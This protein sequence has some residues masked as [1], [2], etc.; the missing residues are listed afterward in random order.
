MKKFIFPIFII[1]GLVFG[2][3]IKNVTATGIGAS[4]DG[5]VKNA[6][7]NAL[8][9]VVGAFI[10][11][12]TEIK[13]FQTVKD[14]ILSRT[15]GFIKSYD[16][17]SESEKEGQ[18][19][20]KITA[21][22]AE[23]KLEIELEELNVI[24]NKIGNPSILVFYLYGED[25]KEKY[26]NTFIEQSIRKVNNFLQDRKFRT[27]NFDHLNKVLKK[28]MSSSISS[29]ANM[30]N[31]K[32][33]ADKEKAD[34]FITIELQLPKKAKTFQTKVIAHLFNTSTGEE[35]GSEDGKS[36]KVFY[37]GNRIKQNDISDREINQSVKRLMPNVIRR[38][39]G[40]WKEMAKD[41]K[42]YKYFFH[43]V[44]KG[45]RSKR[46]LNKVV[47]K[48]AEKINKLS[49]TEFEI[50]YTGT[51]DEFQD[52]ILDDLIDNVYKGKEIDYKIE[53]DITHVH[54]LN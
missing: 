19:S 22:V 12:E 6:Q 8:E 11:S 9:K 33:V 39:K 15:Q 28:D 48:Y 47:K 46:N 27:Y 20:V 49:G 13:D 52:I 21:K 37:D 14:D 25:Q 30:E 4:L 1:I 2:S 23:S 31:I 5:A 50:W 29:G 34:L 32:D 53:R 16:L 24:R 26:L 36:D 38:A 40:Y 54:V 18:W 45:A 42:M 3:G 44:P 17:I 51:A 43:D 41:G 10:K 7:R 35:L